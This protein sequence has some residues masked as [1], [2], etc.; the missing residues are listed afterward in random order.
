MSEFELSLYAVL[1]S[2]PEGKLCTYG[3]LAKLSGFPTHARHVGRALSKLPQETKLPW[4]RVV[5]SQGKI[6]LTGEGLLRQ[7]ARLNQEG[8]KLNE[9]G[10]VINFKQY[11]W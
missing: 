9:Q 10:K 7:Q 8:I 1:I 2:L 6:S 5:N 3:Q 11:L 4:H